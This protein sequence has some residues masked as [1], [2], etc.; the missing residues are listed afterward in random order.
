LGLK[1]LK[2]KRKKEKGKRG[3][4]ALLIEVLKKTAVFE[5]K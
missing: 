4:S 2:G 5:I 3:L 1:K